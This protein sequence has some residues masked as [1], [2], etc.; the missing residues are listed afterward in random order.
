MIQLHGGED[1]SYIAELKALCA[2][3]VIKAFRA[4]ALG[5]AGAVQTAADFALF[6]NGSGGTGQTFDWSRLVSIENPWFL[7]GGISLDN[8]DQ[9]ARLKPYCI[10]VSTGAETN[11]IKDRN[12]IIELVRRVK[13][14]P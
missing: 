13:Q 11:G 3:P 5:D 14:T 4:E 6:D 9:A 2:A 12:K 7:A 1:E 10:D 8:I